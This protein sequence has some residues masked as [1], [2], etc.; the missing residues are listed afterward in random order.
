MGF[1]KSAPD[2]L[3]SRSLFLD[4]GGSPTTVTVL[5]DEILQVYYEF[6]IYY[7]QTDINTSIVDS[8]TSVNHTVV[9]RPA[10]VDENNSAWNPS[11]ALGYTSSQL[12]KAYT[13]S[14]GSVTS[15][16]SGSN[17]GQSTAA[18]KDSYVSGSY[19]RS[20]KYSFAL[21][22]ANDASGIPS[23]LFR[24]GATE[25]QASFSPAIAKDSSKK[26]DVEFELTVSRA[27]I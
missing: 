14:L 20:A 21:A 22:S 8:T 6:R 17:I 2:D 18:V 7:P 19:T 26:W 9:I 13:G 5:S 27:S 16:P 23:V 1:R 12:C 15:E 25:W 24:F 4:S 3:G 10:N 11:R